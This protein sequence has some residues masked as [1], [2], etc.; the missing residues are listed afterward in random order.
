MPRTHPVK[1]NLTRGEIDPLAQMRSDIVAFENGADKLRNVFVFPQGGARRRDG[2]EFVDTL[3]PTDPPTLPALPVTRVASI[4]NVRLIR[5]KFNLDQL[6]LMVLTVEVLYIY[7]DD[8][9]IFEQ[10]IPY[11]EAEIPFVNWVTKDDSVIF[12]HPEHEPQI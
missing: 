9:L 8:V 10:T 12:F 2:L 3:P 1:T 11:A 6:Y 7:R 4:G 5:F